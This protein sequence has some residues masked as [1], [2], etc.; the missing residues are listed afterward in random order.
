MRHTVRL[1]N[2]DTIEIHVHLDLTLLLW[3]L[4][5]APVIGEWVEK[6]VTGVI[7]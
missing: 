7:W 5:H 4:W 3:A 2:G 6:I 1:P